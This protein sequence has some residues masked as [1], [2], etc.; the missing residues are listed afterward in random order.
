MTIYLGKL[1][2]GIDPATVSPETEEIDLVE[3][4][5]I[6][7]DGSFTFNSLTNGSYVSV[8]DEGFNFDQ[9]ELMIVSIDGIIES[10][11]IKQNVYRVEADNDWLSENI[12]DVLECRVYDAQDRTP[13][14]TIHR[15]T[16]FVTHICQKC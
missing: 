4:L 2:D 15:C 3:E 9:G 14:D 11:L 1:Q 13:K 16:N 8:L 6:N 12:D 7:A 10:Q 5:A